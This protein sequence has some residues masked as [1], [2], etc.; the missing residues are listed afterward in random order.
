MDGVALP[1]AILARLDGL[2]R[3]AST[4]REGLLPFDPVAHGVGVTIERG[5]T[6]EARCG[7]RTGPVVLDLRF[8]RDGP[9]LSVCD[10][11][12]ADGWALTALAGLLA[13]GAVD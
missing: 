7:G 10:E 9:T 4:W 12:R 1:N 6:D 3:F 2:E 8:R 11:G 13:R 5:G